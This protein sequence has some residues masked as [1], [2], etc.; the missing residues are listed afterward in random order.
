VETR[1]PKYPDGSTERWIERAAPGQPGVTERRYLDGGSRL[2]ES[3]PHTGTS[4]RLVWQGEPGSRT[5]F[6]PLAGYRSTSTPTPLATLKPKFTA[7]DVLRE[8]WTGDVRVRIE[9]AAYDGF[10]RQQETQDGWQR[11]G[12]E[13]ELG[14]GIFGTYK[15]KQ[16]TV[17]ELSGAYKEPVQNRLFAGTK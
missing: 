16:F 13:C 15:N 9:S 12:G 7:A 1:Q 14:G 11:V 17:C 3:V 6:V 4:V 8:A 2:R 10:L 5:P